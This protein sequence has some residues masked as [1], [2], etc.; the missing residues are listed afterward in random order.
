MPTAPTPT[1]TG[2]DFIGWDSSIV[3]V[4][5]A[6]TYTAQYKIKVFTIKFV[7]YNGTVLSTQSVNYGTMPTAPANPSRTGYDF[8]GWDSSVVSA[9]ADKIYTA[10]YKIQTFTI[11]FVDYN[12]TALSTQTVE[13]GKMPTTPA[14]PSR[15]GYDF[16]GWDKSVVSVTGNATYTA[17]Y[18]V[19]T[20]T[21]TW[22]LDGVSTTTTCE[23]GSTPTPPY[24]VGEN[25]SVNGS[26]YTIKGYPTIEVATKN[27]TYKISAFAVKTATITASPSR[28]AAGTYYDTNTLNPL[29][30]EVSTYTERAV[31]LYGYN[32]EELRGK[33]NIQVKG[34]TLT[35]DI[36]PYQSSAT[37]KLS[38]RFIKTA[39]SSYTDL[40][41]GSKSLHSGKI[42]SGLTVIKTE[43]DFPKTLS[44]I[45]SNINNF[46]NGY[47]S[48][49]FCVRVSA[50]D[51]GISKVDLTVTC[52]YEAEV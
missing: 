45:N 14:N 27:A 44:W 40:G 38:V 3:A 50:N 25:V 18:K 42:T 28:S 46:L 29:C 8:T 26:S 39:T 52:T 2:Y 16:T 36:Y 7:D 23:Y 5:G 20:F 34:L 13:Y 6:K 9:T 4:T 12:G 48:D 31:Y 41:D 47:T 17:Q 1:R 10:Q 22:V 32:F 21:I 15:E 11:K 37:T 51:I 49:T 35:C 19:K 30:L 24:A 43:T 33:T